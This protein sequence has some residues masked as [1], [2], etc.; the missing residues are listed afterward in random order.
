MRKAPSPAAPQGEFSDMGPGPRAPPH[1]TPKRPRD[2][3]GGAGQ[4]RTFWAVGVGVRG[5]A[6]AAFSAC[7]QP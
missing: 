2:R 6:V 1:P 7:L 4:A 5:R 3:E